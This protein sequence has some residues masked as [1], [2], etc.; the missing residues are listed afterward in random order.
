MQAAPNDPVLRRLCFLA[1]PGKE[2][3]ERFEAEKDEH[4]RVALLGVENSSTQP[5]CMTTVP[6]AARTNE[7]IPAFSQRDRRDADVEK[8][9]VTEETQRIDRRGCD[10]QR[11][12]EKTAEQS[13]DDDDLRVE[14]DREQERA[15][16]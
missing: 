3:E 15:R 14:P 9:D 11:R 6:S 2:N 16:S 5:S 4:A 12:R 13:K 8:R 10:K 1:Q 7:V